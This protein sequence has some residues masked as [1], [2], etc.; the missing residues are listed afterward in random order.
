MVHNRVYLNRAINRKEETSQEDFEQSE[1]GYRR[2]TDNTIAKSTT[3]LKTI[4][5]TYI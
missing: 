3:G 2:K 4:N 1:S 5:K